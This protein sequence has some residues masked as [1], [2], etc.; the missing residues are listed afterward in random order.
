MRN[1]DS[2]R[3]IWP[4]GISFPISEQEC[5]YD[6]K[7]PQVEKLVLAA[8]T[9]LL[10]RVCQ[11]RASAPNPEIFLDRAVDMIDKL[12]S[13]RSFHF[14][15][16]FINVL[17][18]RLH[19]MTDFQYSMVLFKPSSGLTFCFQPKIFFAFEESRTR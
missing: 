2:L 1:T 15:C 14:T 3:G 19:F 16:F 10:L 9:A 12:A 17:G 7:P 13:I 11:P 5:N 4:P 18:N 6:K 8:L